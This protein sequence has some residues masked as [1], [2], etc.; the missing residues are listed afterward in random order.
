MI[1]NS[2]V[3]GFRF[4]FPRAGFRFDFVGLLDLKIRGKV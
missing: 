2:E 3:L 1:S 4:D